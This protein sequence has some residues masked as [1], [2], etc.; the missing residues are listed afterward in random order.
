MSWLSVL[1]PLIQLLLYFPILNT[2]EYKP[3]LVFLIEP[4]LFQYDN[5]IF[6]NSFLGQFSILLNSEE[7]SNTELALDC[8]KAHGGT[9]VMWKTEIFLTIGNF[10]HLC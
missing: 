10:I 7:T 9:L 3:D 2:S 4:Q 8:P 5:A 1:T 6:A